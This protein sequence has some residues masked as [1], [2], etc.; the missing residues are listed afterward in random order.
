MTRLE[1]DLFD[2]LNSQISH[3]QVQQLC[4]EF[5]PLLTDQVSWM[6]AT[7]NKGKEL[8]I[9][10]NPDRVAA[11]N[12]Q[13]QAIASRAW[14][15]A[16]IASIRLYCEDK[17]LWTISRSKSCLKLEATRSF[18]QEG[19]TM[20]VE[21]P[22]KTA[23]STAAPKKSL[24]PSAPT[25]S[26][27]EQQITTLAQKTGKSEAQIFAGILNEIPE[28]LVIKGLKKLID[29]E[30]ESEVDAFRQSKRS[31]FLGVASNSTRN[32]SNN[33]K[34]KNTSSVKAK[35][36]AKT[37]AVDTSTTNPRFR[38]F[39]KGA[40]INRTLINFL[41]A[42]GYDTAKREEVVRTIANLPVTSHPEMAES[43]PEKCLSK[44][45][46]IHRGGDRASVIAAAQ[47]LGEKSKVDQ[48]KSETE[49]AEAAT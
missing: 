40:R 24:K 22:E 21:A 46:K 38:S 18:A 32:G 45:L 16:F 8:T 1:P 6:V 25:A 37:S 9:I 28:A 5:A 20:T 35:S 26:Q 14:E 11:I 42:Q 13:S 47:K 12:A 10:C 19:E 49:P 39:V 36:A 17:H 43:F 2:R 34:R 33:N 48:P 41:V 15:I 23:T 3:A 27:L 4:Q 31:E 44:I 30:I 29:Q 7:L